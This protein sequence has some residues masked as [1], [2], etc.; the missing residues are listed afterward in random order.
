MGKPAL[1][2]RA[3]L[4]AALLAVLAAGCGGGDDEETPAVSSGTPGEGGTLVWAVAGPISTTDPLSAATRAE[5]ILVRQV[6][7]PLTEIGRAHV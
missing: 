6:N 2:R 7:E 3:G 1:T 5:E 4:C